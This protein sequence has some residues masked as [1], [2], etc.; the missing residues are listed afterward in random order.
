MRRALLEYGSLRK[1]SRALRCRMI[2]QYAGWQAFPMPLASWF[3]LGLPRRRHSALPGSPRSR[4]HARGPS[5]TYVSS[6]RHSFRGRPARPGS[7]H[8][9]NGPAE[10]AAIAGRSISRAIDRDIHRPA[11]SRPKPVPQ[12]SAT[13]RLILLHAVSS[14]SSSTKRQFAAWSPSHLRL[15]SAEQLAALRQPLESLEKRTTDDLSVAIGNRARA[16]A[17]S[18]SH[19]IEPALAR[20][21]SSWRIPRW[22]RW[23]SVPA[24]LTAARPRP[25]G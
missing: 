21:A 25:P 3:K 4:R 9:W 16:L 1:L 22:S 13:R 2:R 11:K 18:D 20:L 7:R 24:Q 14:R 19:R 5:R 12:P 6:R 23:P 10:L 8:E 17:T 15:C